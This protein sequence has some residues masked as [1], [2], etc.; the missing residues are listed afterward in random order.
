[1]SKRTAAKKIDDLAMMQG[2]FIGI[3]CELCRAA[4]LLT[5][6]VEAE[7][8]QMAQICYNCLSDE[9]KKLNAE[10]AEYEEQQQQQPQQQET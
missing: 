5:E 9:T 7:L 1:M 2:R 8:H 3:F 10:I 6:P 4:E